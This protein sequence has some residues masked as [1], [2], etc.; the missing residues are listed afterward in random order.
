M[1]LIAHQV[2]DELINQKYVTLVSL[3]ND[4]ATIL[5]AG[6]ENQTPYFWLPRTCHIS[7]YITITIQPLKLLKTGFRTNYYRISLRYWLEITQAN[8]EA[9]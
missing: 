4:K 1:I 7:V 8:S 2:K 6:S 9:V 5:N 3:N